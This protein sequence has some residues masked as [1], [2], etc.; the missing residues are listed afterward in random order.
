[1]LFLHLSPAILPEQALYSTISAA[2][3][4]VLKT[5]YMKLIEVLNMDVDKSIKENQ[6]NTNKWRK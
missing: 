1:M 5:D 2:Q 3:E 6:Q 4:K